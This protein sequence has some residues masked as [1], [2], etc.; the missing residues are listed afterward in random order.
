MDPEDCCPIVSDTKI[1]DT[2]IEKLRLIVAP[3]GVH[4]RRNDSGQAGVVVLLEANFLLPAGKSVGK[5]HV[6]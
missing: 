4:Y 1:P 3:R 5:F 6:L 2:E